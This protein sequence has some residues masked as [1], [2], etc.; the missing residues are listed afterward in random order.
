MFSVHQGR[1]I[2]LNEGRTHFLNLFLNYTQRE[3]R[4]KWILPPSLSQ[5]PCVVAIT[6]L[7]A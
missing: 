1:A 7:D 4:G 5:K 3:S 6:I 2:F